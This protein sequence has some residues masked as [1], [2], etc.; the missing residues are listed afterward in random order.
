M[1][2]VIIKN[3]EKQLEWSA[4]FESQELAQEWLSRQ[5]GKPNRL[6]ERLVSKFDEGGSVAVDENGNPIQELLPAEFSSE[7]IDISEQVAA[8]KA[9]YDAKQYLA[10][11]DWYVIRFMD[12][13]IEIPVDV[14]NKREIARSVI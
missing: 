9:K 12:S 6:P 8:E 14:K 3:E 11:T 5:I 13:G 2:K 10:D 7:I 1:F 4:Q